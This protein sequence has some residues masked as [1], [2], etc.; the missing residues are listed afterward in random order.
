MSRVPDPFRRQHK[1]DE[2]EPQPQSVT[3]SFT[4]AFPLA[5]LFLVY[6]EGH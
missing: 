4:F 1:P 5:A 2:S 3:R 6:I